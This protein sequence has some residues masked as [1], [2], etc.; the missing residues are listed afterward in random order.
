MI[1]MRNGW[2]ELAQRTGQVVRIANEPVYEGELVMANRFTD[3]YVFDESKRVSDKVIGYMAY[4]KLTNGF[5]KTVYW[6]IDE[7]KRHALRY[8]QTYKRGYGVWVDNFDA[9]AKKTLVKNLI[10][11]YVPKSIQLTTATEA[12]QAAF[13]GDIDNPKPVYVDNPHEEEVGDAVDFEEVDTDSGE[14]QNGEEKTV[15]VVEEDNG[16]PEQQEPSNGELF[17]EPRQREE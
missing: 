8:S 17:N 2:V 15:I 13:T 16:A 10:I 4:V 7:V 3:E 12:D 9:M 5:E 1:V 11:K 14:V 6:T